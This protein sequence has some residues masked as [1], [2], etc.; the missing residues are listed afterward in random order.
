MTP[1]Q[2]EVENKIGVL[3]VQG[4]RGVLSD[5]VRDI[6]EHGSGVELVGDV[7]DISETPDVVERTECDAVVWVVP[8]AADAVAPPDL[9]R[10][11]PRLR[12][13]AVEERGKDGSLWLMRPHR[14]RL[15]AL[16]VADL[17]GELRSER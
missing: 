6:L 10:R 13:V 15:R 7:T 4:Q 17:I 5:L 11:H 16:G 8:K 1:T 14:K 9:L 2:A 12:I 3:L